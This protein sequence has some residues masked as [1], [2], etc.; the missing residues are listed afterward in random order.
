MVYSI[1]K[2]IYIYIYDTYMIY[3]VFHIVKAKVYRAVCC[4]LSGLTILIYYNK[5]KR[6]RKA[7]Y[8]IPLQLLISS[9]CS[10]SSYIHRMVQIIRV[11]CI[12]ISMYHFDWH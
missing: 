5:G 7:T 2:Y 9:N 4:D 10:N 1:Y 3:R 6:E 8:G 12:F 11:L